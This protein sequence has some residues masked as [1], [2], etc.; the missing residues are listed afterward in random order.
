MV[1][2]ILLCA[3]FYIGMPPPESV[4]MAFTGDLPYLHENIREEFPR[5]FNLGLNQSRSFAFLLNF[6]RFM[7]EKMDERNIN[8]TC[9]W[10]AAEH[11]DPDRPLTSDLNVSIGNFLG[12]ETSFSVNI[13]VGGSETVQSV[14][15]ADNSTGSLTFQWD[16][17]SHIYNLTVG[18]NNYEKKITLPRGRAGLYARLELNRAG[19]TII[20]DIER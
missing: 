13:T 16:D 20:N 7:Y 2:A 10:L 4:T 12:L 9:M 8:F 11:E 17:I 15:I 14:V 18:F 5:A 6:T 1:G 19:E 3:L